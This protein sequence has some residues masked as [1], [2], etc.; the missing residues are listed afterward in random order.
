MFFSEDIDF[1]L[2]K[3]YETVEDID[4]YSTKIFKKIK[5]ND[6]YVEL[7][8]KDANYDD[9]KYENILVTKEE[10][11]ND[12]YTFIEFLKR[13]RSKNNYV[14]FLVEP[15]NVKEKDMPF[16]VKYMDDKYLV[17]YSD[18]EDRYFL[19]LNPDFQ[20]KIFEKVLKQSKR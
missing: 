12:F 14:Y 18:K 9:E 7:Q 1:Y 3:N 4:Y 5:E 13:A 2:R 10:L 6:K 20:M 15:E 19:E 11:E 16:K 8:V 17:V